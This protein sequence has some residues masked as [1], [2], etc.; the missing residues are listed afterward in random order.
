MAIPLYVEL[1][2]SSLVIGHLWFVFR[3]VL[4]AEP[5]PCVLRLMPGSLLVLSWSLLLG[6]FI[7]LTMRLEGTA[8]SP[9]RGAL[10]VTADFGLW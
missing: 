4:A 3:D 2:G 7:R 5:R 8:P 10:P 6:F 9:A 1:A